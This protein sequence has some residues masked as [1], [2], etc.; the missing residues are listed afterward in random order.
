MRKATLIVSL[1]LFGQIL[2]KCGDD[3]PAD[4]GGAIADIKFSEEWDPITG[5]IGTPSTSFWYG[6]K[7]IYYEITLCLPTS[8]RTMVKKIWQL[9]N[10]QILDA[11]AFMPKWSLRI[12]GEIHYYDETQYM[13]QGE[14]EISVFYWDN[15]FQ[16]Y[17][18]DSSVRRKFTI[19]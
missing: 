14:Y 4:V 8:R 13:N 18:Y 9:N 6:I 12:C 19:Q 1:I 3:W 2:I 11:D 5:Q 7:K 17:N 15:G 10:S 16:E